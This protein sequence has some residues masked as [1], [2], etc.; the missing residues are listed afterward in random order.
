M[1]IWEKLMTQET[2]FR[3]SFRLF[4][5][6]VGLEEGDSRIDLW[7]G[8]ITLAYNGEQRH[9]HTLEDV[10]RCLDE[11][12]AS[13]L[14][15]SVGPDPLECAI[16]LKAVSFDPYAD[17]NGE[18]CAAFADEMLGDI[19]TPP[20]FIDKTQEYLHALYADREPE[21]PEIDLLLDVD[22]AILGYPLEAHMRHEEL[23][24]MECSRWPAERYAAHRLEQ[25]RKF[26]ERGFVCEYFR[27]R[28]ERQ[29]ICNVEE[30][31]AELEEPVPAF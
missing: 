4:C 6:R 23:L 22:H 2:Q 28:Y 27:L 5:R 29:A 21:D 24:R 1:H 15:R 9:A 11:Y 10:N 14:A 20:R 8:K 26:E 3:E 17:N 31:I 25:L 7:A 16:F 19:G 30:T 18:R 12:R 13:G